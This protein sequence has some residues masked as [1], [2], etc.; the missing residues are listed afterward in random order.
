MPPTKPGSTMGPERRAVSGVG[1]RP[2]LWPVWRLP[3]LLLGAVLVVE[4]A[5]AALLV[6][7]L[8]SGPVPGEDELWVAGALCV[9][10][11]SYGEVSVGVERERR[12]LGDL[13]HVDLSS[14]WTFATTLVLPASHAAVVATVIMLH[15]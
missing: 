13:S 11:L 2:R 7:G 4:V 5:A 1:A 9:L 3:R 8:V 12:R 6:T 15:L 10:G 14:V